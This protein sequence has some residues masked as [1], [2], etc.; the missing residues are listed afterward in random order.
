MLIVRFTYHSSLFFLEKFIFIPV[1]VWVWVHIIFNKDLRRYDTTMVKGKKSSVDFCC[2]FFLFSFIERHIIWWTEQSI[3]LL[4]YLSVTRFP[5]LLLSIFCFSMHHYLD[6][7][8]CKSA[9]S[10]DSKIYQYHTLSSLLFSSVAVAMILARTF[11]VY[12]IWTVVLSDSHIC[13]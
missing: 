2:C 8:N 6:T 5:L 7:I 11:V 13:R 1:W 4:S 12:D 10:G 9:A 3:I